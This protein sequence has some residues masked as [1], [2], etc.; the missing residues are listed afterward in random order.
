MIDAWDLEEDDDPRPVTITQ[1]PKAYMIN[2]EHYDRISAVLDVINKP[3]IEKWKR[4]EGFEKADRLLKEANWRGTR[5]HAICER[6]CKGEPVLPDF[7]LY[8]PEEKKEV[9]VQVEGSE[10]EPYYRGYVAWHRTHIKQTILLETTVW[11][12][13]HRYAGTFDHFAELT[14]LAVD[15]VNA[16][17][18]KK[19]LE[20]RVP[21]G[22]LALLDNKTSG[23][24]SAT[25]ALQLAAYE[26]AILERRL[27]PNVDLRAVVHMS[28][29]TPG[30]CVLVPYPPEED[31][32]DMDTWLGTLKLYRYM[33]AHDEDWKR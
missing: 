9:R 7:M 2:A 17:F 1:G 16:E 15:E 33:L 28:S 26:L 27:L 31:E 3:G 11:S 18:E 29:K 5:V 14:D 4:K 30:S 25:Y 21:Y 32:D 22:C 20:L 24:V 6:Y 13:T 10:L 23:Y 8:S 19:R 12:P